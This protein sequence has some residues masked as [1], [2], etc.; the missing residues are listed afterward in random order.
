MFCRLQKAGLA[1]NGNKC[2]F[3]AT[4]LEFPEHHVSASGTTPL[5]DKVHAILEHSEPNNTHQL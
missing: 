4:Q 5:P 1:A 2:L 3:G